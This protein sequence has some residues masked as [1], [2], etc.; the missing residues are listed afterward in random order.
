[1]AKSFVKRTPEEK[2]QQIKEITEKLDAE[3]RSFVDS[4]KFKKY[5]KTMGKFHNYSWEIRYL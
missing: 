5:L 3:L 1:M 4:D 2:K